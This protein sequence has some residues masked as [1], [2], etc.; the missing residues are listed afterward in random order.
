[1]HVHIATG[2][3]KAV[4]HAKALGASAMQVFSSNP[5]TYRTAA[6]DAAALEPLPGCG[7]RTVSIRARSTRPT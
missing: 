2:Y 5:R 7:A 6:I 1:M 3:A 4:E